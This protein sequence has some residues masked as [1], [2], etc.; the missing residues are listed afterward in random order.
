MIEV[1]FPGI[2]LMTVAL[3]VAMTAMTAVSENMHGNKSDQ[4]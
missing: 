3:M 1:L 2:M 4:D